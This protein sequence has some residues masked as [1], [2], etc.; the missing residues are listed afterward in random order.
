MKQPENASE[1]ANPNFNQHCLHLEHCAQEHCAGVKPDALCI[2]LRT[3]LCICRLESTG[4]ATAE[5]QELNGRFAEEMVNVYT[6]FKHR[7]TDGAGFYQLPETWNKAFDSLL[8]GDARLITLAYMAAAHI[9]DDLSR[10]LA[11]V[12]VTKPEYD[13]VLDHIVNCLAASEKVEEA[14]FRE[15]MYEA[16]QYFI[17]APRKTVIALMRE[18][19]WDHAQRR[20]RNR[21]R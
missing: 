2:F 11:F 9:L 19:A 14:D 5:L 7:K 8:N 15:R 21:F 16:I 20:K 4:F 13:A 6:R 12:E 18:R 3:H 17:D 10:A 1:T